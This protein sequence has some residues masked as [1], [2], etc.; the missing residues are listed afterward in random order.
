MK[1]KSSVCPSGASEPLCVMRM[2]RFLDRLLWQHVEPRAQVLDLM[3]PWFLSSLL[4]SLA[5]LFHDPTK[6]FQTLSTRGTFVLS[7]VA[8]RTDRKNE[9]IAWLRWLAR[10]ARVYECNLLFVRVLSSIQ[11]GQMYR[12]SWTWMSKAPGDQAFDPHSNER[13]GSLGFYD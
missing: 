4:S 10:V 13:S 1:R 11:S 8:C 6:L 5:V 9:V 12:C 7:L 3:L 2:G